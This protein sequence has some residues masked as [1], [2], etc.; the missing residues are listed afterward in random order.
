MKINTF[1]SILIDHN[2]QVLKED[3]FNFH[4]SR[5]KPRLSGKKP[6]GQLVPKFSELVVS[7]SM[8]VAKNFWHF[9]ISTK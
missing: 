8:L 2:G 7:T 9:Y 4:L 5:D 6:W 1:F 3:T